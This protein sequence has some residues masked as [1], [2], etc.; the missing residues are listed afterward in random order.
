[1][2]SFDAI[3]ASMADW[4]ISKLFPL[5]MDLTNLADSLT[6]SQ[7][8]SG[9]I[10]PVTMKGL[11]LL[12]IVQFFMQIK[13]FYQHYANSIIMEVEFGMEVVVLFCF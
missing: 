2:V 6:L 12:A 3:M 1:M 10:L 4:M 5:V 8:Y 11:F 7:K 9:S 13:L